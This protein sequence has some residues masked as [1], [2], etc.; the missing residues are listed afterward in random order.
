MEV[1]GGG[2]GGERE[3]GALDPLI[4]PFLDKQPKIFR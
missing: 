4:E 3:M 2:G 1:E